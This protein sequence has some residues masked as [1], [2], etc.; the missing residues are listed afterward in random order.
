MDP[1]AAVLVCALELLGRAHAIAPIIL[2]TSPPPGASRHVEAFV[3]HS[4]DTIYLITTTAVL[5]DAGG[6]PWSGARQE[7]CRKLASIIVHEEWHV[8]NGPDERGAY[9][10]QLTMLQAVRAASVTIAGVR[11][12]MAAVV[13]RRDKR[14]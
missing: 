13:A 11:Q 4:P 1:S 14:N 2:L 12:S 7:A 6:D 10:A 5:H 3:T 9:L 8:R